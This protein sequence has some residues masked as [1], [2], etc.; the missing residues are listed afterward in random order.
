[1]AETAVDSEPVGLGEALE[2]SLAP[3]G[4]TEAALPA[5]RWVRWRGRWLQVVRDAPPLETVDEDVWWHYAVEV[6]RDLEQGEREE[7]LARRGGWQP[8][9]YDD[10]DA[11]L[12]DV[13]T[14]KAAAEKRAEF[15]AAVQ[16]GR[17]LEDSAPGRDAY[18]H[19]A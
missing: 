13:G 11:M 15:D 18:H 3:E 19:V 8:K 10:M 16:R 5:G 17:E 7:E 14:E 4:T 12:A 2:A 1:M 9:V 6:V